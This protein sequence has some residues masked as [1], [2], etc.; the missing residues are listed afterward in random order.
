MPKELVSKVSTS[1]GTS[2][3]RL[4][5]LHLS[6]FHLRVSTGWSQDVVLSTMLEDICNRYGVEG[7]PDFIFLTGDI[8]FSGKE[9][10]YR[11]AEDFIRNL[12]T[13]LKL[14]IE[15]VCI[16]PG[17]HDIDLSLEEDAVAGARHLLVSP[18]EVDRFF[19]NEGR[20]KTLFARQTAFRGFVNRLLTPL[21]PT[22]SAS[23]YAHSRIIQVG[24]LRVRVLLLDSS[25]LAKGGNSDSG[26]LLVGERQILDCGDTDDY[27][28]LT[29]ALLHHPF[30]WLREFEQVSVENLVAR[31]AQICL[32]GHV[33]T[34]DFRTTDGPLGRLTS[35][36]AGATFQTR[37][38]DN[39]YLWCSLDLSTGLGEK[40][41]HRY[42]HSEHCWKPDALESWTFMP[43]VEPLG[44]L[45]LLRS[46]LVS[47]R[48]RYPSFV[49]CLLGNL[50]TEVPYLLPKGKLAFVACNAQLPMSP[51]RCGLLIHK[52][53]NHF[54]W[55][56][57]WDS[58]VWKT[59]LATFI[60]ELDQ[61][62]NEVDAIEL[63]ALSSRDEASFSLLSEF[64]DFPGVMSTACEEIRHLIEQGELD[65]AWSVFKRWDG[66]DILRTDE[67]RELKRLEVFIFLAEKN[68]VEAND[69]AVLL[70]KD[71]DRTPEDVALAARC[72][73]D[74][75]DPLRAASLMHEALD[76][77]AVVEDVKT[78]ARAIAGAAG[79]KELVKRVQ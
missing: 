40:V 3:A 41:V 52:L 57:V 38:T 39:S 59:Q 47:A 62:F 65:H 56:H 26:A 49:T 5:W 76:L 17:N 15:R 35:F 48:V 44:D 63:E 50:Q 75:M 7:R 37:T 36:T 66:Q 34:P 71:P 8:A 73:L 14:P 22:Y 70:I 46:A 30:A 42:R 43:E 13:S 20:R 4:T 33:H 77:G 23:S 11:F 31:Y 16:V 45:T 1:T 60:E 21:D 28:C 24:A 67:A 2:L 18:T 9:E 6:D 64:S 74:A 32:R 29:F 61:F 51:N 69:R 25:W 78:T 55:K 58:G 10:E 53:R 79:D 68:V 19:G 72:A 54:S 27:K 12:C